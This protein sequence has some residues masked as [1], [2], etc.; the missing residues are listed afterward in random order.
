[1]TTHAR[2][3]YAT[4]EEIKTLSTVD[5]LRRLNRRKG[6]PFSQKGPQNPVENGD[7]GGGGPH[8]LHSEH[9]CLDR[10]SVLKLSGAIMQYRAY[11]VQ[12]THQEMEKVAR[13]LYTGVYHSSYK[14]L[15]TLVMSL[16]FQGWQHMMTRLHV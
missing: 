11:N 5:D 9:A 13:H 12:V 6:S 4:F 3:K 1:M 7:G 10:S 14:L 16:V 15:H 8:S 2:S